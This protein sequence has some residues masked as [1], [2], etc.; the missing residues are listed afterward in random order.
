MIDELLEERA[1]LYASGAM[2]PQEREQFE[3]ILE[4]HGELRELVRGLLEVGTAMTLAAARP[5]SGEPSPGLKTRIFGMLDDRAQQVAPDGLIVTDPDGLVQWVNPVFETMCG[6]TLE[7]M[8]G[9]KPGRVLQ[10]EKTDKET[11]KRIRHAMHEYKPCREAMVNYRKNGSSYWVEIAITPI[12]DDSGKPLWL[13]AH[14]HELV[15]RVAV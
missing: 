8:R 12:L 14:E 5:E 10:G 2:L 1:A 3:F 15:D 13:V 4:F 9:K 6:Y 7:E 11:V